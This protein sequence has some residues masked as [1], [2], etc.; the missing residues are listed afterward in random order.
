[1]AKA[2]WRWSQCRRHSGTLASQGP[3]EQPPVTSW[4][5]VPLLARGHHT[6]AAASKF[7]GLSG[8]ARLGKSTKRAL[9]V[10]RYLVEAINTNARWARILK[11]SSPPLMHTT[12]C[13]FFFLVLWAA[14]KRQK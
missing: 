11:R 5:F 13:W 7:C 10:Q 3:G 14:A 12:L 9:H 6:G 8:R 2:K 1:M 4:R